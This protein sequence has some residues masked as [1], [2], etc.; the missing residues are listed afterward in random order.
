[1]STNENDLRS[2]RTL[3]AIHTALA[4]LVI[5]KGLDSITVGA[6]TRR[7][8]VNR[9]T[10]Y[11]HYRDKFQ[12]IEAILVKQIKDLDDAMGPPQSR[13]SR[14]SAE[15][16][17]A[18]WIR[19]FKQ[20]EAN[21]ELYRAVLRSSEG[22]WFQA[23]LRKH[24]EQVLKVQDSDTRL[25]AQNGSSSLTGIPAEITIAFSANLFISVAIWWLDTQQKFTAE[26]VAT[27]LRLFFLWGYLGKSKKG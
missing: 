24:V 27:W 16:I 5:E 1:M 15:E 22:P 13:R 3:E 7:A 20:I 8:G 4:T 2:R 11:R 6:L 25:S 17:P 18:P 9:T 23:R 21:A 14:F 10:F 19:F 12:A 26:Q